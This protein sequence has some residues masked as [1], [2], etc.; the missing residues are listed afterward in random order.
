[1]RFATG[2]A[3]LA[4]AVYSPVAAQTQNDRDVII[5]AVQQTFDAMRARD[6]AAFRAVMHPSARIVITGTAPNGTVRIAPIEI[7]AFV[8]NIARST[9]TIEERFYEPEVRIRND[10]ATVWTRYEFFVNGNFDHCGFD[11]FQF[12]KI[13]GAWKIIQIADTQRRE[14]ARCGRGAG[15]TPI[16]APQP[17]RADTT[18]VIATLRQ[19]FDAMAA[20]DTA[21]VKRVMHPSARTSQT[22]GERFGSASADELVRTIAGLQASP[23]ERFVNPEVRMHDNLATIWTW[24]DFHLGEQFTHCG[25]DAVQLVRVDDGWKILHISNNRQTRCE[26][27]GAG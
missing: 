10:L 12:A 26:A 14:A 3:M 1:M 6:T 22:D 17:D 24:Y 27:G 16:T 19:L 15:S 20:R 21:A 9:G 25:Y 8:Q 11:S 13:G 5:A 7:D 2:A 23:R 18:E 4:A